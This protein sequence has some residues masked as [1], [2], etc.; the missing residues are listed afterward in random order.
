MF[1]A[2]FSSRYKDDVYDRIWWPISYYRWTE[3]KTNLDIKQFN[4]YQMPSSVMTTTATPII[5]NQCHFYMHFAE[6]EKLQANQSRV[7]NISLNGNQWYGPFSPEYVSTTTIYSKNFST[8][9][10][11][12][13]IYKT[14]SSTLPPILNA[15][16]VYKVIELRQSE[17]GQEEGMFFLTHSF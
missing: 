11:H 1:K 9:D 17:T 12:I 2:Y 5:A 8:G 15:F 6:V 13:S 10:Q 16:E 4:D 14:E 3:L 7:I